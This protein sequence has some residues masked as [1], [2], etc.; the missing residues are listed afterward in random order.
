[1]PSD[2]KKREQQRK[3]EAAKS[4]GGKK[5]G[6]VKNEESKE[7]SPAPE[8]VT[9]GSSS[10]AENGSTDLSI[11][12]NCRPLNVTIYYNNLILSV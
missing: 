6:N 4:K 10:I 9:N 7:Q 8:K 12:G 1:M 2:A 3:K 5:G 11:E